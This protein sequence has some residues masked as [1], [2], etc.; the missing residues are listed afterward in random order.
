MSRNK[1]THFVIYDPVG[2]YESLDPV[3]TMK[4]VVQDESATFNDLLNGLELLE[5]EQQVKNNID[6][7]IAKI[8]RKKRNLSEEALEDFIYQ[9]DRLDPSQ[10]IEKIRGMSTM[11]AKEY[12]LNKAKLFDILD[13]GYISSEKPRIISEKEDELVSHSRGFGQGKTPQD[14]LDEFGEFIKINVNKIAALKVVCTSPRDLT[15]EGLKSLVM[16]LSQNNFTEQRLNTAWKELKNEEIAADIINYIHRYAL[17]KDL[18]SHEER[19]KAAVNQ[20]RR[21]HNFTKMELDWLNRIEKA[22]VSETV[23][24]REIFETGSFNTEGGFERINKIFSGSLEAYLQEL[25]GYLYE[26]KGKTA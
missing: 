14:Y 2:V 13:K 23:I 26:D 8:H 24:D 16:E 21:K 25:N 20:L 18:I 5:T 10:F 19:I 17:G 11:D 15:R 3:N 6:L 22:L 7:I 4:P 1:K 12:I 9:C